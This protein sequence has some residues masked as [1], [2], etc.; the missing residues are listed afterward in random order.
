MGYY[1]PST[2]YTFHDNDGNVYVWTTT[3]DKQ[4]IEVDGLYIISGRVKDH[5]TFRGVAETILTRCKV[6]NQ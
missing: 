2:M 1:G 6:V 3:S 4:E 5:K